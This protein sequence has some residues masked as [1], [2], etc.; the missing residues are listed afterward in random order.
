MAYNMY[1]NLLHFWVRVAR[2]EIFHLPTVLKCAQYTSNGKRAFYC[3]YVS[4][5]GEIKLREERM[6]LKEEMVNGPEKHETDS[7]T[8]E[9]VKN[10]NSFIKKVFTC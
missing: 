3:L 4:S 5:R 7:Y 6:Q 9:D 10:S 1:H 8:D 2:K